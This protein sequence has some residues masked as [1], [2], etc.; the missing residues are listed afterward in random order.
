MKK[1]F[2]YI[3][4]LFLHL[5]TFAQKQS[6]I[7]YFGQNVGLD[8]SSGSPATIRNGETLNF[9]GCA[10]M[11]DRNGNLL[12]YTNGKVVY[13]RN[14]EI[15]Q[16]GNSLQGNINSTQ[17]AL[18]VP[19]PKESKQYDPKKYYIFTT[20]VYNG[21]KGLRYSIV[22]MSKDNGKGAII[23]SAKNKMLLRHS[24][25]KI[26]TVIHNDCNSIW[27][28]ALSTIDGEDGEFDNLYNTYHSFL[29]SPSG[30]DE[31]SVKTT[32][33]RRVFGVGY[34]KSS[35][36]GSKLAVA[37]TNSNVLAIYDF[38]NA[39]GQLS[40][41]I[42][43]EN[44]NSPYGI[45]FSK[46]GRHLFY[47]NAN[48]VNQIRFSLSGTINA[49]DFVGGSI[50][51]INAGALQLGIDGKIYRS[52]YY[53]RESHYLNVIHNP[54]AF[55]STC[56]I[57]TGA[58]DTNPNKTKAG[59]PIFNQALMQPNVDII[60]DLNP[61][62]I[63]NNINVCE[64][65]SF[66]LFARTPENW[67]FQYDSN[68]VF[69]WFFEGNPISM[70][71]QNF[72]EVNDDELGSGTYEVSILWKPNYCPFKGYA[73]F[74]ID[75]NPIINA[76]IY[77]NQCDEDNDGISELNLH[78]LNETLIT[79]SD[80]YNITYYHT[81]LDANNEENQITNAAN[82]ITS[83][84]TINEPLW[85]RVEIRGCYATGTIHIE[86]STTNISYN[87]TLYECDDFV[88][89]D[90]DNRD[91]L[92]FF[93][94]TSVEDDVISLFPLENQPNLSVSYFH[95]IND[96]L[97]QNNKIED[98]QNYRNQLITTSTPERIYLRVNNNTD[99]DCVGFGED[100]YVDLIVE[101]LPTA[102][103]VSNFKGCNYETNGTFPFNTSSLENELL[104]GQVDVSV[105]YFDENDIPI[106]PTLPNPFISHQQIITARVTNNNT[107]DPDGA[108]YD[109]TR[110][111][112]FVNE[113]NTPV[114]ETIT[115]FDNRENNSASVLV[116]G[117][118][119]YEFSLNDQDYELA[120]EI[121]GHIF[122]N[123]SEGMHTVYVQDT[124]GCSPKIKK[125]FII[126]RFP[127]FITPNHDGINDT[128][129]VYG[130]DVFVNS[131]ITIY[132]RYGKKIT[133][134]K[135]NSPWNGT[136]LNKIANET[137]Y[138]FVATFTDNEGKTYERKGHFSLKR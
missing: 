16:N 135:N 86:I 98:P 2:F 56:N 99:L 117:T 68:T 35:P 115:I 114:I 137:E 3:L 28:V 129:S 116:T 57:E 46:S 71:N 29:L 91:G 7:W 60:D 109:E 75:P 17:S 96:A 62:S 47:S 118:S 54:N 70:P 124:K 4:I 123:L 15:M 125:E 134:L 72:L 126:I 92:T 34:M 93:N 81:E 39:T 14:H 82:Y 26:A 136:Y 18:I 6:N 38:D 1:R 40:N 69:S 33:T 80:R 12:F 128:F 102:H 24:A 43:Y 121:H 87:S 84:T 106:L 53:Q 83:S 23:S 51:G 76:P 94:L 41:Q 11:C 42:L 25:E 110:I 107:L 31:N 131:T 101:S 79:N 89:L 133:H 45:E 130:G 103:Q 119:E 138:W 111:R 50:G 19:F 66:T 20:D 74:R 104:L 112:F 52:L 27:L 77:I 85:C 48:G 65:E 8:F 30:I 9:A 21:R 120:N 63:A 127:K 32:V 108:C 100:L 67:D 90:N 113:P 122:N 105:S 49:T 64:G 97:L 78:N 58:L 10:S 22:D 55:G 59:L 37:H 44:A 132:N 95:N 13:N 61:N 5:Q 73:N 88:D 36:R